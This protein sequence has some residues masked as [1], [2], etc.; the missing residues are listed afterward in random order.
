MTF[1]ADDSSSAFSL[2]EYAL[3]FHCASAEAGSS[4][5]RTK[6]AN[7]FSAEARSPET[8]KERTSDSACTE[9]S[10]RVAKNSDSSVAG[11][12][13]PT[14]DESTPTAN[15]TSAVTRA[16]TNESDNIHALT[17]RIL[18][19]FAMPTATPTTVGDIIDDA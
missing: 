19:H 3:P 11:P 18:S 9:V 4:V 2:A 1:L 12:L 13:R 6:A 8:E 15:A 14:F 5:L 10:R 16:A 17:M 7:A